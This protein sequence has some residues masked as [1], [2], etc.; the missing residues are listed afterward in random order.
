L[1][2]F[3]RVQFDNT[4]HGLSYNPLVLAVVGLLLVRFIKVDEARTLH[5]LDVGPL[6]RGEPY[7]VVGVNRRRTRWSGPAPR[8]GVLQVTEGLEGGS[9][10]SLRPFVL[11]I[12]GHGA[13][14]MGFSEEERNGGFKSAQ[15]E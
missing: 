3:K 6:C 1:I 2:S 13:G 7:R 14:R 4:W 8:L 12:A 15:A 9:W 5:D 11:P 10:R